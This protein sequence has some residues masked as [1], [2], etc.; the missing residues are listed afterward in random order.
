[1]HR[2]HGTILYRNLTTV[3]ACGVQVKAG[4]MSAVNYFDSI[5]WQFSLT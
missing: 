3:C 4:D 1:M 2:H 5:N